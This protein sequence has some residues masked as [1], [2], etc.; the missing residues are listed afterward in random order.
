ME[1]WLRPSC[2]SRDSASDE[3]CVI[4]ILKMAAG[5]VNPKFI[6]PKRSHPGYRYITSEFLNI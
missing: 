6:S 5:A 4:D 3:I 1:I 2:S